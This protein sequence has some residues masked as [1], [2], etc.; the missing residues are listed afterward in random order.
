MRRGKNVD[1]SE[2]YLSDLDSRLLMMANQRLRTAKLSKIML[3]HHLMEDYTVL[4]V[5]SASK[6]VLDIYQHNID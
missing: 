2:N 4:S 5:S 6:L 1:K 3:N